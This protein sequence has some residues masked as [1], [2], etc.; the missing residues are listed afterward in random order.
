MKKAI[1]L[2][3]FSLACIAPV[4][5]AWAK[6][7]IGLNR[8]GVEAGLV[9]PD[10]AGGTLG[11]GAMADLGAL[12]P[13]WSLSTYVDY[14]SKSEEDFGAEA[15]I[16]DLAISGRVKYLFPVSSPNV[17]PYLGGGLGL[18]F[19]HSEVTMPDMD[20]GGGFIVPG[21][22]VSES[23]T[24]LGLDLGGGLSTPVGA[25]TS[26]FGEFWY[27]LSDIDQISMK[28]GVS[29]QIGR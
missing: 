5:N 15:S 26:L 16:S 29:F 17:Q 25:T 3:V 23:S 12:A 6:S 18:H 1:V 10:G 13:K 24:E 22:S 28:A 19:Y 11:F 4:Q 27:T 14:W 21:F 20:L 9:D 8:L 2:L 7:D